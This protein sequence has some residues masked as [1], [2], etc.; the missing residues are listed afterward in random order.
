[1][2][3]VVEVED[4]TIKKPY[5]GGWRHKITGVQYLNANSQTGPRQKRIP[6][7]SQCTR[8]IQTV[9]TKTRFTETPVHRATQMWRED[10][11]V[12]NVSD[13]YVGPK[14]YETYD[15]MQS[16]LDIEGKA[17][18]I[19][20]YY[21]AYRIA[22][23]IKESAATYRQFVADCKRHEEERL[24]AYKRRHQHDIIRKTYPSSRFDFD[25]LYNL[26]DQWKHSQMKRVAGIFFKGAQRAANVMLLN[27]SVDMLR[28]IDQLKQI[29]KTEFLEEKKIKFLTFHCAPIEWNGYKGKPTQMITVKV[30]RAREFKRLYDNLSC[31]NST[32]ESRTEL[33]VMLKNSLKY[34]HCQA[35]NEL[36]YLID[37]EITLMSRGVRNKWL[38]QLRR[39]IETCERL[40]EGK[41]ARINFSLYTY[42]LN[43]IREDEMKRNCFSSLIFILREP[44]IY[45]LIN[46][47]WHGRSVISE[48]DDLF[49]LRLGRFDINIEWSPWNC[50]LLTEEEAEAHYYIKDFRTVYAQ[51]LLEKIFLAQEQ[52]KSHFRELVVF[53][54]HYRESSRFYMVQKRK[55][56]EAPKAIHSYA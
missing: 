55:D 26:M 39:R 11:Y 44:G 6:W 1:M 9:E 12:P 33:L 15:E 52:A 46:N 8:P 36:V 56:Y 32:V 35:V 22:R 53:E 13:K 25:M 10:C 28:E 4:R 2:V 24:L 19:Q 37:Q 48:N 31:K 40:V 30:Q 47:I 17:T 38:N 41:Q 29:V 27:K 16:K 5:L 43:G 7:N 21:R 42:L 23:F 49:K 50:I 3:L 20:K 14:P 45:H 51:S 34:H 54:K 18:M